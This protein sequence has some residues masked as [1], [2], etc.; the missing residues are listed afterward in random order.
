MLDVAFGAQRAVAKPP[1]A[2]QL[3]RIGAAVGPPAG[4]LVGRGFYVPPAIGVRDR[5]A[6]LKGI[7]SDAAPIKGFFDGFRLVDNVVYGGLLHSPFPG[8]RIVA[9]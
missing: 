9:R 4:Q 8:F 5:I 6:K 7:C 3:N 2:H 1:A